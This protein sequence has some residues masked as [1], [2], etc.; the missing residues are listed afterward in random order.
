MK[1]FG[2]YMPLELNRGSEYY[3]YTSADMLRLNNG[4]AAIIT[5]VKDGEF[6][7]V[8]LPLYLCYSVTTALA[9]AGINFEYYNIDNNFLP[10]N[11]NIK[12]DE[13]L[14]WP[15][16]YG[17][18]SYNH[19]DNLVRR[20]KNLIIDNTQAFFSEPILSVYNIYSCRK[21]FGVSD[22][23]YLI[24]NN[25]KK[26]DLYDSKSYSTSMYLSKSI[27]CGTN[28]AYSESLENEKRVEEEAVSNMS[29][30]TRRL[31]SSIDY[32]GCILKRNQNYSI[33]QK[34][35][36]KYNMLKLQDNINAP[37][38]YPLLLENDFRQNLVSK[39]IFVSQWWKWIIN[40]DIANE[41]EQLLAK[42]LLPLPIDQRYSCEDMEQL[43]KLI[44]DII[45]IKKGN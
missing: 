8:Y 1:E 24:H 27:E 41:W 10:I 45:T 36:D 9:N 18:Q 37:M 16:Y 25:L 7:K 38:V 5:A 20:Y 6:N 35:L 34:Y 40:L 14:L 19:I 28:A 42:N 11:I 32:K 30:L 12:D 3:N 31:M 43:A 23:A 33:L 13:V 2:G 4:R 22:G 29:L 17:V 15:N 44:L 39:R 26:Q 21:F